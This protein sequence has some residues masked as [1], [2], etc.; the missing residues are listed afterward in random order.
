[1]VWLVW[2]MILI[3]MQEVIFTL[4]NT[5]EDALNVCSGMNY[6]DKLCFGGHVFQCE[7][8]RENFNVVWP[9]KLPFMVQF[10]R[11]LHSV[12]YWSFTRRVSS[13]VSCSD[14]NARFIQHEQ[15]QTSYLPELCQKSWL[16]D[17]YNQ[18]VLISGT[19]PIEQ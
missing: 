6:Y 17:W 9:L 12:E 14:L 11:A 7:A 1:M 2:I 19:G 16:I 8:T 4:L 18:A 13:V 10:G 3:T 15:S 5:A